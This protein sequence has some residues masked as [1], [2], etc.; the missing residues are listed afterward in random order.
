MKVIALIRVSTVAQEFE[1]Q[2]LK[3]IEEIRRDGYGESDIIIIEDKESGR[4]S[5]EERS[6]INK[7][8]QHIENEQVASVYV[9]E[10]SRISRKSTTLFSIRDYLTSRGINLICLNPY[11]KML[12]ADGSFDEN[13]NVFFGIFSTLAENENSIR[14][15]R[16][17][18]GKEKKRAEGKLAVGKPLYGYIVDENHYPK[19]H[20]VESQIVKEIFDRY[21]N[22]RESSGVIAKD[23][24]LRKVFRDDS[25]KLLTIQNYVTV[26]LREKRYTGGSIY[27]ALVPVELYDEAE[28]I[29]QAAG[30]RFTRKSLTKVVYPLQGYIYTID[31]YLLTIGVT[32][33]RYLKMNDASVSRISLNMDATHQLTKYVITKY[34]ESGVL[35]VNI[36]NERLE[37]N[38]RLSVNKI[39]LSSIDDKISSL[40]KENDFIQARIIKGRLSET[41][42]D[43]MIDDNIKQMKALEDE[44]M[45][46]IYE[47]SN[48]ENRLV[49]LSNS[50]LTDYEE[51]SINDN[52]DLRNY[53]E[54]YLKK[55][56]VTKVKFSTYLLEYQFL[57]GKIMKYGFFST[58]HYIKLYD[59][60]FQEIALV[61]HENPRR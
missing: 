11:F 25:N 6:G 33:N 18:R 2:R 12:K 4:L 42:G 5:E 43:A 45:S 34:L 1:S 49:F 30:C 28:K 56:I 14:R 54:K 50:L 60:K 37:L 46:L 20:P 40:E 59:E 51:I 21:V 10:L 26:V 16:I 24:Y 53:V 17:M 57:D 52:D 41:K 39:K 35:S 47:N 7:L 29:R 44:R 48:I 38:N 23:L 15:A 22:K 36:E 13:S 58:C 3:V 19:P 27:P 61:A 9:Y 8:K 31:N 55:I 32:N